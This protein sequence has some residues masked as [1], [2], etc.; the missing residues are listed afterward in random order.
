MS[1]VEICV[2]VSRLEGFS[3]FLMLTS[4]PADCDDFTLQSCGV[5]SIFFAS[6]LRPLITGTVCGTV[7]V[8]GDQQVVPA[9]AL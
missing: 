3:V 2:V 9:L 5:S 6:V 1:V 8:N 7:S 4:G